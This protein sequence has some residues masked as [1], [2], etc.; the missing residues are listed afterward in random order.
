M[1]LWLIA[2]LV[3]L[4]FVAG[5]TVRDVVTALTGGPSGGMI[6]L[7]APAA[8]GKLNGLSEQEAGR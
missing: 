3:L 7:S 4:S 2:L 5:L 1:N 8:R 6:D